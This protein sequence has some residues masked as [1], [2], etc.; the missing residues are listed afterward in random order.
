MEN[1]NASDG[2][3]YAFS[4]ANDNPDQMVGSHQLENLANEL[5]QT[6]KVYADTHEIEHGLQEDDMRILLKI[7]ARAYPTDTGVGRKRGAILR[8]IKYFKETQHTPKGVTGKQLHRY[9]KRNG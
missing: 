3:R 5:N 7:L 6:N 8:Y 1:R 2:F 4:Y 9:L